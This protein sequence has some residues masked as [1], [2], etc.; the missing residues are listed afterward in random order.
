MNF[1]A[2]LAAPVMKCPV[3][4]GTHVRR[5][6]WDEEDSFLVPLVLS[7]YRC[8]PCD[9]R[10]YALSG[11]V[12]S[13]LRGT[14]L[15]VIVLV[16]ILGI[17]YAIN[18]ESKAPQAAGMHLTQAMRNDGGLQLPARAIAGD[19]QP[20][21]ELGVRYLMGE[22]APRDRAEALKWLEMAANG[23][24]AGAR[25]NLGIMYRT[26]FGVARDDALA[27][28]WFDLAARQN[29]ADAQYQI[30]LLHKEGKAIPLDVVKS[31]AWAHISAMQG[32][33]GAIVLRENLRHAMTPQ[34]VQAGQNAAGHLNSG[35]ETPP[36]PLLTST[37]TK[38]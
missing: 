7:P 22:G 34:Q 27:H 31:Y 9:K 29:H 4:R 21:F 37:E 25:Y 1:S 6:R 23:G 12:V 30:A 13:L 26:G 38:G 33:I 14:L 19:A 5:S 8:I 36:A 32:H 15:A 28:R 17:T 11:G 20:Q 16:T 2:V 10:F 3:C 18:Q 35:A 24:H